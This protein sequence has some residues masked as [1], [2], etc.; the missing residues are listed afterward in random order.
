MTGED[1]IQ[2]EIIVSV[3]QEMGGPEPISTGSYSLCRWKR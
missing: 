1:I 3:G 2:I